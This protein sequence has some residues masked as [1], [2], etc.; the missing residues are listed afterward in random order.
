MKICTHCVEQWF[1]SFSPTPPL[2]DCPS[3][4]APWLYISCKSN[5]I[6]WSTL[7]CCGSR[8]SSWPQK[9]YWRLPGKTC[10]PLRKVTLPYNIL[11]S[12]KFQS[13]GPEMCRFVR[14]KFR[15]NDALSSF[16]ASDYESKHNSCLPWK[17]AAWRAFRW[18]LPACERECITLWRCYLMI[19]V[20]VVFTWL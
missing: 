2:S 20:T 12:F 14:L 13:K 11:Y 4:Q 8:K 9:M 3:F 17:V 18:F 5:C 19:S 15:L 6:Y 10:A 1:I 7:P 16:L